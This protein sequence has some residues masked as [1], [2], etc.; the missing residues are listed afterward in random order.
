M[1]IINNLKIYNLLFML[2]VNICNLTIISS[3]D[4]NIKEYD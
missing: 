3:K 4:S 1:F 2:A